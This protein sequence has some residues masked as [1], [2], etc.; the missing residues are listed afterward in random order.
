M[1]L[2]PEAR[3]LRFLAK[4]EGVEAFR[5][6]LEETRVTAGHPLCA[7]VELAGESPLRPGM[8]YAE[9][10]R[11]PK[12]TGAMLLAS[13]PE[14]SAASR[15]AVEQA[16][17]AIKYEGYLRRQEEEAKKLRKYEE[18]RIPPEFPFETVSG[19]SAEVRDKFVRVRPVSIGQAQRIPG[20]TPAAIAL[21]LV[22]LRRGRDAAAPGT[23]GGESNR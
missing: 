9:A 1:G 14:L 11:R 21:L 10:L 7:A 5:K 15:E 23:P 18:M 22:M 13:D 16:E 12:V 19:L 2:L 4:Q 17:L 3:Y 8:T 6:R 20:V